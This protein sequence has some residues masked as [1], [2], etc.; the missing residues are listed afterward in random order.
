MDPKPNGSN[1]IASMVPQ[2][3]TT[4]LHLR[5]SQTLEERGAHSLGRTETATP[6]QTFSPTYPPTVS[7]DL[8]VQISDFL[9]FAEVCMSP[10]YVHNAPGL[11]PYH[12]PQIPAVWVYLGSKACQQCTHEQ[13]SSCCVKLLVMSL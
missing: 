12:M 13:C 4:H 10:A 7:F 5:S 2:E 11:G 1:T 8:A 9:T 6:S 3:L